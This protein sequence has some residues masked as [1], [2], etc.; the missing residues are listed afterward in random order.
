MKK[1]LPSPPKEELELLFYDQEHTIQSA[2]DLYDTSIGVMR[3]WRTENEISSGLGGNKIPDGLTENPLS[4]DWSWAIGFIAGDGCIK[5]RKEGWSGLTIELLDRDMDILYKVGRLFGKEDNITTRIRKK[6]GN[7]MAY[8]NIGVTRMR[9][10]LT[11]LGIVPRKSRIMRF[12][13]L[14]L[15]SLPDYLRGLFDSDGSWYTREPRYGVRKSCVLRCAYYS[16][17]KYFMETLLQIT[18][19]IVNSSVQLTTSTKRKNRFGKNS[20]SFGY[21]NK[22][23][24]SLAEYIYPDRSLL[25]GDRKYEIV[26]QF[27]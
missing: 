20:Y 26:K 19:Q 15:I 22:K 10:R 6:T 1:I 4:P 21:S 24:I 13:N 9:N 5:E 27:I 17:S 7:R 8:L 23:A 2:A 3:R 16:S 12:P 14:N 11:Q 18:N 25:M